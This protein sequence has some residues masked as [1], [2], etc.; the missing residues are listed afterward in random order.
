VSRLFVRAAAAALCALSLTGCVD[1]DGPILTD[2][3]PLFGKDVRLQFYSLRKGFV[4]EPEQASFKWDGERYVHA[5]GG[6]TDVTVFTVHR[7]EGRA[8]I[9]QSAAAKRPNIIE[10]AVAHKLAEGVFQVT[11]IDED[12]ADGVTRARECKKTNDSQ[13]RITT[14][15]QLIAFARATDARQKSE[16]GL[17]LRLADDASGPP[18]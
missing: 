11:A 12:D 13:C 3:Q 16:G 5:G 1:S 2:A 14:R 8:Y 4:D 6:M 7:F 10:Y 15:A 17:V 18:R 9:V